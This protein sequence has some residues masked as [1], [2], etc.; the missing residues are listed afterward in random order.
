MSKTQV[1]LEVYKHAKQALDK[2]NTA[3]TS[4]LGP[5]G[6]TVIVEQE[7]GES[8]L[9]TKDGVTVA[10]SINLESPVENLVVQVVKQAAIKT[11]DL[12][13]DGTTTSTLL[14][15]ALFN[16][17]HDLLQKEQ[18]INV[19]ELKAGIQAGCD[20]VVQYL[21]DNCKKSLKEEDVKHVASISSNND[22]EVSR[23]VS[24]AI[25]EVGDEGLI[26]IEESNTGESY[27]DVVEGL[28][29]PRG[30]KSPY[31]ATNEHAMNCV[32]QDPLILITDQNLGS[33]EVLLPLLNY[34]SSQEKPLLI[35][36]D[37][38][39]A[40]VLSTLLVNKTRGALQSCAVRAPDFGDRKKHV[41]EDIA[42]LTGG[43]VVSADKGLRV[44]DITEH[45]EWLGKA[46]KVVITKDTTTIIDALGLEEG[47]HQRISDI[48]AQIESSKSNFEKENLQ[49]RLSNLTGGVAVIYIGSRTE[50][51]LREKRDRAEDALHATRAA[52]QEGVLPGAGVSLVRAEAKLDKLIRRL[53]R[54]KSNSF[55]GGLVVFASV[56]STPFVKILSNAGY[57]TEDINKYHK[58]LYRSRSFWKGYSVPV[59][60]FEDLYKLGVIDPKKVVRLALQNAVSVAG[61]LLTTDT[62]VSIVPPEK[63]NNPV[64][65]ALEYA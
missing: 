14:T 17:G 37:D 58:V 34:C 43:K 24:L 60:K 31:F 19:S 63:P 52:V 47:I 44:A 2:L 4:T 3:V 54:R 38:L 57:S 55:R 18:S 6:K 59:N 26:S 30:F 21:D 51:E 7:N 50:V 61:T 49:S 40:E 15:T 48:K 36:C 23:L 10:K 35:I 9:I 53:S 56:L 8:P 33:Y 1:N 46:K 28:Q 25:D 65:S 45:P 5:L 29:F 32:L 64:S 42:V 16:V 11:A 12:V 41:L 27:L 20:F 39:S 62:I 22:Q 13:G